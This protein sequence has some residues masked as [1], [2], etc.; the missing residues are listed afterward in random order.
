VLNYFLLQYFNKFWIQKQIDADKILDEAKVD[1]K[2]YN[3]GRTIRGQWL[4]DGIKRGIQ[5]MFILSIS[6][7]S[8]KT[9]LPIIR[10]YVAIGFII[11]TDKWRA[12]DSCRMK[13]IH[14]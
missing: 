5:K 4:F 11:Y 14:I 6:N 12:Y 13:I 2:K 8:I 7:Q 3:T 9:L 1:E 10:K